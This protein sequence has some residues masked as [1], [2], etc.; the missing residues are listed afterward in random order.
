M[1]PNTIQS[2]HRVSV[3]SSHVPSGPFTRFD[4]CHQHQYRCVMGHKNLRYGVCRVDK[5]LEG[6]MRDGAEEE[7]NLL[8][9]E[10]CLH[11]I[12]SDWRM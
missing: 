11:E 4:G 10:I 2:E 5:I 6:S 8:V 3:R 7:M 9:F 12:S 1:I